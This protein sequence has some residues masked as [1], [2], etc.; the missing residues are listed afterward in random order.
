MQHSP[1]R[2]SVLVPV[3]NLQARLGLVL[4]VLLHELSRNP[5]W[6]VILGD[7]HSED[8]TTRLLTQCQHERVRTYL[9]DVHLGRGALRN[10]L[11]GIA[12][13]EWLVFLDGDCIPQGNW[14]TAYTQAAALDPDA[15]W[16]GAVRY[17]GQ[18]KSGLARFLSHASG[19]ARFQNA[20][21]LPCSYFTTGNSMVRGEHFRRLGGFPEDFRGWGGEDFDLGL[22]LEQ[23]GIRLN[24]A[25][26]SSVLHPAIPSVRAYF[27]RLE[28]FGAENL[29][30]LV[31]S[32]PE[33]RPIFHIHTLQ[34]HFW[35]RWFVKSGGTEL[36]RF[37][38]GRTDWIPWPAL[39]YRIAVF[40]SYA[41]GF[42]QSQKRMGRSY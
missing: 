32:Y 16:V 26:G 12:Q 17:E 20:M 13:G 9:A 3:R 30:R 28:A 34:S 39:L 11:A 33:H 7:D 42:L 10:R 6:E 38:L 18:S 14:M 27:D 40:G 24:H 29:W 25:Q 35:R 19:P 22:R 8:G 36:L 2:F 37:L 41:R 31:E 5:E 1:I 23:M 15:T 21:D 4:P